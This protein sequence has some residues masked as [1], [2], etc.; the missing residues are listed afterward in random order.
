MRPRI[1]N[2]WRRLRWPDSRW[3]DLAFSLAAALVYA[4]CL[5]G[6]R[7]M[8]PRDISW[9]GGDP[10]A[11]VIGW[12]LFRQDPQPHW[13]L[14]F[15]DRVGYPI[16]SSVALMDLIPL[17]AL[18]FKPFSPFLPS[19]FQYLGIASILSCT[20]QLF[21]AL[22]L[23]RWFLGGDRLAI[24]LA[25]GFFLIA[26][27][28]TYRFSGHFALTNHWLVV[29]SLYL[30]FRTISARG[31]PIRRFVLFAVLLAV[32]AAAINPY[33]MFLVVV[34]LTA[35]VA[36]LLWQR[37]L[38]WAGTAGTLLGL[39]VVSA[40]AI[41]AVGLPLTGVIGYSGGAGYGYYSMNLLTLVD[42]I[43]WKSVFLPQLPQFTQGQYE[44]YGYLGAGIL[45]LT[46][47]SLPFVWR[48]RWSFHLE[49]SQVV[50]LLVACAILTA[51]AASTRVSIGSKLLVDLD[52]SGRFVRFLAP[53]R[54]SGRL[55][56]V[57]YYA[58]L[59]GILASVF[60]IFRRRTAVVL[61]A[62]ALVVQ[63]A[64]TASVRTFVRLTTSRRPASPL[65]SPVWFTLAALHRNLIVL[66]A[67][68]CD[69]GSTPGLQEGFRIF[70]FLAFEQRMRTN[71][72]YASRY[73]AESM[74][75][76]CV[77]APLDL[78][79][80]PLS[81]D[82]AYVVNAGTAALI[83]IGPSGPNRCHDLDGFTLC[84]S[85]TDFGMG[86]DGTN[87]LAELD[88]SDRLSVPEGPSVSKFLLAGWYGSERGPLVWSDGHGVVG[89]RLSSSQRSR[90]DRLALRFKILVGRKPVEY[91]IESG[92]SEVD[93]SVPGSAAPAILDLNVDLPLRPGLVQSFDVVTKHPPRPVD[94]G[95][96]QDPREIGLG[97][98]EAR[99]APR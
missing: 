34:V 95:L 67:W 79:K 72:Y 19:P 70:G 74:R 31:E 18:V 68:Q 80:K 64:D 9:L 4:T 35:A 47:V 6:V 25:S 2:L 33:L 1:A 15:T 81:S 73:S 88:A 62:L 38:R 39:A 77:Q 3:A 17:L 83:E 75:Y 63:V 32:I 52:P 48:R 13:P 40:A 43:I 90:Y 82:S 12:E 96:N 37:R 45:L 99:L 5:L 58:I 36:S 66:P 78:Y 65:R 91:A 59:A 93:G 55:F 23:F 22:R 51:M 14:T 20:L 84:S 42:P 76:H 7:A 56:W 10:S 98:V 24:V 41:T 50:P 26:P 28:L 21:F 94:I 44:G 53:L 16:G 86:P 87:Y 46:T 57:P 71:S 30:L 97:L 11:S 29:A 27:P 92:S 54:A 61:V 49:A 85:A 60:T 69:V 8:D 89:F